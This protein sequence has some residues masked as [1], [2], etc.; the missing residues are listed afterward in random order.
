MNRA[1]AEQPTMRAAYEPDLLDPV[2]PA[3]FAFARRAPGQTLVALHNLS[4]REQEWPVSAVPLEGALVDV[5]TGEP[6][7]ARGGVLVLGPYAACWLVQAD[8]SA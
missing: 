1:R 4:E 5:L 6:P 8:P 3:V 7:Q 2:N